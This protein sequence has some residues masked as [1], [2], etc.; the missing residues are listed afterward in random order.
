ML[1]ATLIIILD[2]ITYF[3]YDIKLSEFTPWETLQLLIFILYVFIKDERIGA[4]LFSVFMTAIFMSP[5]TRPM[6]A[7]SLIYV[8]IVDLLVANKTSFMGLVP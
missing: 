5:E 1:T 8:I 3:T 7:W 2:A 6:W 4:T